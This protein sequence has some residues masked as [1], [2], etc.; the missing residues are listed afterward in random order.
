MIWFAQNYLS[1]IYLQLEREECRQFVSNKI[2]TKHINKKAQYV[3]FQQGDMIDWEVEGKEFKLNGNLYDVISLSNF[4]NKILVKCYKDKKE[5]KILKHIKLLQ[6]N[7]KREKGN[8]PIAKKI[9]NFEYC[10]DFNS[11][12]ILRFAVLHNW[13]FQEVNLQLQNS[14]SNIF[15][16]P[17]LLK[18]SV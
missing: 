12:S 9:I 11:N 4:E 3:V 14:F 2:N 8:K 15:K 7:H 16:P 18:F 5:T 10:V 13:T 17:P 6:N 1:V